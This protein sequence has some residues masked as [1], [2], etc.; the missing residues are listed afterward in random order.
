[1]TSH[2]FRVVPLRSEAAD[3]ARRALAAGAPDHSLVTA[4]APKSYPCRHCLKCANPGERVILFPFAAIEPGGP[5]T[6]IGPIFVHAEA[7]ERYAETETFPPQ[8]RDGRAMRA[9]DS[10]QN[11]I[12]AL[13]V[14][15][16]EAEACIAGLL[17]NS[18]ADFINVHSVTRG[19]YTFGIKRA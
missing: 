18:A 6:D 14:Q 19:C 11:M 5:W 17:E 7:C 10:E 2:Y 4:D 8:F 15:G 1:M 16:D 12:D 13:V 9:Y 3:A